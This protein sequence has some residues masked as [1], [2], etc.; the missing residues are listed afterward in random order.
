[1]N[2]KFDQ[3]LGLNYKSNSQKIRVMS[4]NWVND[5]IFC[6]VCGNAR[7]S[8]LENNR[9]V[10]DFQCPACGEIFEL[11]SKNGKIGRKISDGAYDTMISRIT[12]MTN[13]DL[14]VMHYVSLQVVDLTVVPKFLF[15]PRIIEK[16]KPLSATARRAGWV[17]CNILYSDIPTQGRIPI[18]E[19]QIFRNKDSIV[20]DYARIKRL[21]T[22]SIER[23]GW[24]F[25]VLN[26]VN[27][28]PT[29]DFYLKDVYSFANELK[30]QHPENQNVEAKIR[31][32]LQFLR[33]K[34]MIEFLERG[35]YRKIQ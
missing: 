34:G 30:S 2:L 15:T 19:N 11:K 17:G 24:L 26:C 10:A 22:E 14:L 32:Q 1:M 23:R 33:D 5:N 3:S 8:K 7:L 4:E 31:Q 6:P 25:D 9:P 13:P 35:H 29:S 16:R 12:S 21:Q 18:I 20:Q 28:I 27:A